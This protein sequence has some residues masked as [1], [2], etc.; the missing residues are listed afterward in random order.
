[1]GYDFVRYLGESLGG[2]VNSGLV[3]LFLVYQIVVSALVF[4]FD[5]GFPAWLVVAGWIVFMLLLAVQALR[6]RQREQH[7]HMEHRR[8][9]QLHRQRIM[10][11]RVRLKTDPGLQTRCGDCANFENRGDPCRVHAS[12]G[13]REFRFR[14]DDPRAYCLLWTPR[15]VPE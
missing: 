3:Y 11:L 1:M 7:E 4:L 2:R 5:S 10:R 12:P 8:Q 6:F 14:R 13:E 9:D 15:E